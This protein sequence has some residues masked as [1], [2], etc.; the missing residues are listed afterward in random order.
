[1]QRL[2]V[3]QCWCGT[4]IDRR[5]FLY[6]VPL[7]GPA[8]MLP[9]PSRAEP[10][11]YLEALR[12]WQSIDPIHICTHARIDDAV[13]FSHLRIRD[14]NGQLDR[15][16][17]RSVRANGNVRT[18]GPATKRERE[19]ERERRGSRRWA[20]AGEAAKNTKSQRSHG[21]CALLSLSLF[22]PSLSF[23]PSLLLPSL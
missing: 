2:R 20:A 19:N 22:L 13:C 17:D 3:S 1:V 9:P 12:R 10:S 16:I 4:A 11:L 7:M 5:P 14:C 18:Q 23:F 6:S 15:S 21:P 8:V